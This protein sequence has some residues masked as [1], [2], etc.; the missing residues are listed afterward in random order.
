[1]LLLKYRLDWLLIDLF[2]FAANAVL[3]RVF[4]IDSQSSER[5]AEGEHA[6]EPAT[7]YSNQLV[8][9]S[10]MFKESPALKPLKDDLTVSE[11]C[12]GRPNLLE[13]EPMR[14][15]NPAHHHC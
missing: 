3:E 2:L 14:L 9:S 11:S 12:F 4:A 7:E 1:M 8:S 10:C 5:D 15:V 6:V 13:I